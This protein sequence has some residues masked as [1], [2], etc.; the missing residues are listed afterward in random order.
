MT[1]PAVAEDDMLPNTVSA[2]RLLRSETKVSCEE[3]QPV[4]WSGPANRR[5]PVMSATYRAGEAEDANA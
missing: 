1:V 5:A 3:V 4:L 2:N